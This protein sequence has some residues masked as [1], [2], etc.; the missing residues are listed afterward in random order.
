MHETLNLVVDFV[1]SSQN[2]TPQTGD[3]SLPLCLAA[4]ALIL[5]ICAVFFLMK[6]N[7]SFLKR[8]INGSHAK[9]QN[10]L[11]LTKNKTAFAIVAFLFAVLL[12][13]LLFTIGHAFAESKG[14]LTPDTNKITATVTDDSSISFS[15]CN[16]TNYSN[17]SYIVSSSSVNVSEEAKSV[18]ALSNSNFKINGFGGLL[19]EGAPN[20][21]TYSTENLKPLPGNESTKL[22]FNLENLDKNSA[23]ALCGKSVFEITLTQEELF[24]A[25]ANVDDTTHGTITGIPIENIAYGTPYVADATNN[26]ITIG[27]GASAQ[28]ITFIQSSGYKLD[29]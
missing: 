14:S 4:V 20:G 9:K 18:T 7:L 3:L 27:E 16:L 25:E 10:A 5:C 2:S 12:I 24:K 22:S 6:D 15:E 17:A 29:A 11:T 19:F 1:S 21:S 23:L 13:Y 26:K 28:T 8:T